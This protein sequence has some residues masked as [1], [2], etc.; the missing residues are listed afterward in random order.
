[1]QVPIAFVQADGPEERTGAASD[2]S[3]GFSYQN[4]SE[5]AAAAAVVR[6][7]VAAGMAAEDV[8][9]ISPYAGQVR[10]AARCNA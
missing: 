4:A 7:L 8:C 9:V 3:V 5:A 2:D 1:M 10:G 6:G